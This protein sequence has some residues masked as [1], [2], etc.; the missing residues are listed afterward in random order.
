MLDESVFRGAKLCVVGN[1]NRDIKTTP[2]RC[3]DYLFADGETAIDGVSET[4]GGGGANSAAIAAGLGAECSFIGQIGDDE[5]GRRLEQALTRA[6]V[7]CHLGKDP[8]LVTGTTVNLV[9]DT[10]QRHFLSC[11]LNNAALTFESLDLRLLASADHLLR[12]DLWFSE[13]ML[14]GGNEKLFRAAREAEVQVSIDLNWDPK[15]GHASAGEIERR[16]EA[17]RRLLPLVNL[18]HGNIRELGEFAGEERL[19]A[20]LARLLEWGAGAVV[21]HMGAQGAGYFSG[22]ELVV[23]PPAPVER[24]LMATGTGD[25]LSVCMVLLHRRADISIPQKLHLANRVVAGFI[26]GRRALLPSL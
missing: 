15:W 1:I 4:I 18:A 26:E 2:L 22:C 8:N 7:R 17:V 13:A 6:G 25:V 21:V 19:E 10:G 3:G 23:D 20:S 14:F 16:K 9:Y 24:Q 12:A 11:H 5:T